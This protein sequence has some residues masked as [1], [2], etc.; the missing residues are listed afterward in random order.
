MNQEPLIKKKLI[1]IYDETCEDLNFD[2][3][4][5]KIVYYNLK[6]S[7][8]LIECKVLKGGFRSFFENFPD[9]CVNKT[10][11]LKSLKK[12]KYYFDNQLDQQQSEIEN[13][14]MTKIF[15]YLY[16]GNE[17]DAKNIDKLEAEGIHYVL[18]VTKNIPFYDENLPQSSRSKF[19]FKRIAVN[20]CSNQ[21]LKV[22][23]EEAISFIGNLI[24]FF[25]LFGFLFIGLI[26]FK[27]I[28]FDLYRRSPTE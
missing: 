14:V 12:N 5:V 28:N 6:E 17:L 19:K 15:D 26:E 24:L 13:A 23:Y 18:N 4:P 11:D 21:N 9:L 22:H 25:S 1:I 16:L 10:N 8:I 7:N 3:N 2:T 27:I 20:D